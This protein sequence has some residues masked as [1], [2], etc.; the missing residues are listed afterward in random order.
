MR[1]KTSSHRFCHVVNSCVAFDTYGVTTWNNWYFP[2]FLLSDGSL[3]LIYMASLIAL[4]MLWHYPTH[5]G[6]TVHPGMMTCGAGMVINGG[7]VP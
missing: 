3:T 2:M 6:E 1:N 7:K 4:V 5:N